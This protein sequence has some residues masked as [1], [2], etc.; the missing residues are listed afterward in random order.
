MF[1][2]RWTVHASTDVPVPEHVERG[3]HAVRIDATVLYA[4][5]ADSTGLVDRYPAEFAAQVYK[6]YLYC[7]AKIVEKVRGVVSA[8]DGDRIM[9]VFAGPA[10]EARAVQAALQ[11]NYARRDLIA[12]VIQQQH[13]QLHYAIS[14][15]VGVDTGTLFVAR[16]GIRGADDLVWVGRAANHAAKLAALPPDYPTWITAEVYSQLGPE[17]RLH[18]GEAMWVERRWAEMGA[19]LVYGSVWRCPV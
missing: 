14:H 5:L 15:T 7:A 12:P 8:Y 9:A 6:A 17:W 10:K 19:R 3:N 18:N 16:E 2:T 11:I 1:R 4:D 13:P